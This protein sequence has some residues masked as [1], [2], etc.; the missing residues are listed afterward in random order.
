MFGDGSRRWT[1]NLQPQPAGDPSAKMLALDVNLNV[2][3]PRAPD[4]NEIGD[5]L[6]EIWAE[7]HA[8]MARLGEVESM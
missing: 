1:F 8:F 7:V 6:N 5:A 4:E 2:D 3:E